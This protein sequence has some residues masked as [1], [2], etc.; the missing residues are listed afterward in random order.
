MTVATLRIE[1]D[2]GPAG[3]T[4]PVARDI[5]LAVRFRVHGG[6]AIEVLRADAGVAS[7]PMRET[8]AQRQR[9][10]LDACLAAGL[11]LPAGGLGRM[12]D[13]IARIAAL[14]GISRQALA[15][16]IKA[17]LQAS[18]NASDMQVDY[19]QFGAQR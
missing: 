19:M 6:G 1:V 2:L 15:A 16:D 3:S 9:R 17:A 13:G 18:A 14:E 7:T 8:Q 4:A 12:P 5:D 11:R 10:R